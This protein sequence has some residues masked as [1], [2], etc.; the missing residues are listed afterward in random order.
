[1]GTAS[2]ECAHVYVCRRHQHVTLHSKKR[3]RT[4]VQ[5]SSRQGIPSSTSPERAC[6]V[7]PPWTG[8]GRS[9][10]P[11]TSSPACHPAPSPPAAAGATAAVVAAAAPAA[12]PLQRHAPRRRQ[13]PL[14]SARGPLRACPRWC[15]PRQSSSVPH[16]KRDHVMSQ[17]PSASMFN[18]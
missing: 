18:H 12:R 14:R 6:H 7:N 17:V 15:C 16:H 3:S 4:H 13:R 9:V 8:S 5:Q 1:M 2:T 10:T 11:G